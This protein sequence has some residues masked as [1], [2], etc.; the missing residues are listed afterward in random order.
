[1]FCD[2]Q[3]FWYLELEIWA[4]EGEKQQKHPL[5]IDFQPEPPKKHIEFF[6]YI[7][8]KVWLSLTFLC[9]THFSNAFC[10]PST[11]L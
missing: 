9:R 11:G 1:M 5:K 4:F 7:F 3:I 2:F 10:S 8:L 6:A